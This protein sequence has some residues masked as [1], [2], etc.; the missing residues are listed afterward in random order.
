MGRRTAPGVAPAGWA[1][2]PAAGATAR[3][4]RPAPQSGGFPRPLARAMVAP[5]H[6]GPQHGKTAMRT[7]HAAVIGAGIVGV[8]TAIHLLRAGWRVTLI[9]RQGPAA[10]ASFGNGGV[11]AAASIVPV[12][13]PGMIAKIPRMLLSR[14]G[15]L[16]VKWGRLPAH[17]PWLARFLSHA[18]AAEARR[19]AAALA[20][21]VGQTLA[22][23]QALAADTPAARFIVPG[24]Y[25]FLYPD[26]AA[27]DGDGFGWGL[28]R[29]HGYRW[30]VLEGAEARAA[31]PA[32][33]P[34]VGCVARLHDHGRITD[35]GAYVGALADHAVALGARLILAEVTG[36]ATATDRLTG[37]TLRAPDG[38]PEGAPETLACDAAVV[39]AGA[40]S[41]P[42]AR[43]LGVKAPLDTERGYHIDLIDAQGGPA[44]ASMVAAGKFVATPME[45]RLR[46]A[47]L[48]E[49][50]GL[51]APPS[52]APFDLL[53][54]VARR[55]FPALRWAGEKPWM[56]FRPTLADSIPLIG[57]APAL[58]GAWLG[59]GHQHIGLTAGPRT[60]RWLADMVSGRNPNIDLAPYAPSR[61]AA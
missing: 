39:T 23:H 10:G 61:F 38:A 57:A 15:P 60:G 51:T 36:L 30:D 53:R 11:L 47:G 55:T 22:D 24:F 42:L 28:R 20:P 25:D 26:R 52:D 18:N 5:Q 41:G 4:P 13:G 58:R 3:T 50:G 56:G 35:P 29:E 45:G 43:R 17:L 32:A 48:V 19:A 49:I 7:G 14:D 1:A 33:G 9:D 2:R 34:A 31:V 6:G 54:R 59:F 46:L 37:V 27:Y 21:L 16:F 12:T 40:W 8:A 44:E